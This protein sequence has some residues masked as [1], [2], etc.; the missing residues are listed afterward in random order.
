MN[1]KQ[2]NDPDEALLVKAAEDTRRDL[3][4][5]PRAAQIPQQ[6]IVQQVETAQQRTIVRGSIDR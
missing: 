4:Q 3:E 5:L 6:R 2:V 1:R